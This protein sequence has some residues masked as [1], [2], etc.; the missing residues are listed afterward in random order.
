MAELTQ[1]QQAALDAC[2]QYMHVEQDCGEDED[3]LILDLMGA[4][5]EYLAGSGIPEPEEP[6]KLYTLALHS[7]TLNYYDHRDAVGEEAPLPTGLRPIINQ[8]KHSAEGCL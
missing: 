8:L 1:E 5:K 3:A 4:A 6:S 7:L 2:K